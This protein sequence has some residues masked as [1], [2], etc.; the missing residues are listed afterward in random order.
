MP[1][2][3]ILFAGLIAL[4][5]TKMA[6]LCRLTALAQGVRVRCRHTR[7]LLWG[8]FCPRLTKTK[9]RSRALRTFAGNLLATSA[10]FRS[11]RRTLA[12]DPG[13]ARNLPSP[14]WISKSFD[15]LSSRGLDG[16]SSILNFAAF[17]LETYVAS[18]SCAEPSPGSC[19]MS[20]PTQNPGQECSVLQLAPVCG[21]RTNCN[22]TG[23]WNQMRN[24][25][26]KNGES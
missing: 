5:C 9:G 1:W 18:Q 10:F 19:S 14:C 15:S 11:T 17:P 23:Q 22:Q 3:T 8:W 13:S 21:S 26:T 4:L 6:Q 20:N 2:R 7:R 12:S 25:E 24:T 16:P